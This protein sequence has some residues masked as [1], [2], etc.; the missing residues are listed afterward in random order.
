M[1]LRIGL[2]AVALVQFLMCRAPA[3]A[4]LAA[5]PLPV[6]IGADD[7]GGVVRS[8]NGP[9]GGVWVIAETRD[10]GTRFAK[11]VVTDD[12]GRFVIPDLPAAQCQVWV[13]GYGLVDSP[14]IVS[15]RGQRL[16][17]AAVIAPDRAAAAQYYP[18]IYWFSLLKPPGPDKFPGTGPNGNGIPREFTTRD[19]WLDV[20][21]TNG[22][23]NCHQIGNY[24]TRSMPPAFEH[25]QSSIAAWARRLQS[26]PGGTTMVRTMGR[27]L[28][29]D[30]GHL[31]ALA[32]WTDRIKAGELPETAPPRP[33]GLE[34]NLVVTVRDWLDPKHYA[35]DLTAT[36]KR[37]PTV[38]A[39]GPLYGATELSINTMPV[40]DP[41]RNTKRIVPMPVRDPQQT[42]SSALANP[43][44]ASSPYFGR[45]QVWDSQVN[46]H[47]PAM[48]QQGRIYFTAQVR[49]PTEVPAYCGKDSP[50]RSAQLYPLTARPTG[51]SQ[52]S[53]QVTVYDPRTGKFTFI[54]TCFGTQHLNFA[55][56][57]TN[58]LW[59]SNNT[60]G[61]NAVVGWV[62]TNKFWATNDAAA[63]QGWTA[64]VVDTNGNGRRDEDYNEPGQPIDQGKDTRIPFGLYGISVSPLDGTIWGSSLPH[65]GY[66]VRIDPG[67]NPPDTALAEVYKVPSPGYGIRGM[68]IDRNG[69]VWVPLDSGHIGSFDR[70]KCKG[71]LNG[72]GAET[73]DK[74][75]EGWRFYP[76]P[77]PPM[78]GDTGAAENPYY[79]WVD[80]H[81]IL[82]LGANT[83][84][85]TGNQSDSLHALVG[86]R[87]V[88][89]RVP[90]PMGFFAKQIDGRIDDPDAGWKGRALWA[91]SGNRTPVHIEGIDAPHP[92]APGT[93]DATRSSPLVVQFQL[94]PSPLA[95]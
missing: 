43:V 31:A 37:H 95:H 65:P 23:G 32:D 4:Q 62:N 82:G 17:L 2:L 7:I 15:E 18:A 69:V 27:L 44:F 11:M 52:N 39:N 47:S 19:Q 53:R 16:N 49:P 13:R 84:I 86:G 70:R 26:G 76:L 14:K 78:Q 34:R 48:D 10:L 55:E 36:D 63:A 67:S 1:R 42:P 83:P 24:A 79:L 57:E 71:P 21:K 80:Q 77:G 22:C 66:I 40:L 30:G 5:Q 6:E 35:H 64:L 68:D 25:F 93:T 61:K 90:Y 89:L 74:C 56:D 81:D 91:T 58:T 12:A 3:S 75:P 72:P 20:I 38:N 94:R 29:P 87:I 41:V 54:D 8:A 45:E 46:A 59:F 73:G 9:E 28:T 51:F 60:Q 85:A 88:E 33:A 92:G 50:L